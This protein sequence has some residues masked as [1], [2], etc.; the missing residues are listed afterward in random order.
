M[1]C[2]HQSIEITEVTIVRTVYTVIDGCPTSTGKIPRPEPSEFHVRCRDCG[3]A[4]TY[5]YASGMFN[6]WSK[7]YW[8]YDH[9]S[10][11]KSE[12]MRMEHISRDNADKRTKKG[13]S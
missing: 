6:H 5:R 7:P 2:K 10:L 8:L 9:M 13:K 11:I 4:H 12:H 1:K 3:Y